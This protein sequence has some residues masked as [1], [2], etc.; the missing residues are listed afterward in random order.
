MILLIHLKLNTGQLSLL[1]N[2]VLILLSFMGFWALT[3]LLAKKNI[4]AGTLDQ[5]IQLGKWVFVTV[6]IALVTTIISDGFKERDQTL[7]ELDYFDKYKDITLNS[8]GILEKWQLAQYFATVS[9][10][11]PLKESW[12][13]YRD[14]LRADYNKFIQLQNETGKV[15]IT[16]KDSA[17]AMVFAQKQKTI[18]SLQKLIAQVNQTHV[19]LNIEN[20][21]A[22]NGY[23]IDIFYTDWN[24]KQTKPIA[25]RIHALLVQKFPHT[26]FRIVGLSKETNCRPG[27]NITENQI[28]YEAVEGKDFQELQNFINGLDIFTKQPVVGKQINYFTPKYLS[29]FICNS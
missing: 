10:A 7:K 8:E 23:K 27:Y 16:K 15:I 5:I 22:L 13:A 21:N 2:L 17:N 1:L 24:E 26:A 18:D 28:R 11:G 6:A 12:S 14:S 19:S 25:E 3:K 29:F 9:P 20:D 4:E